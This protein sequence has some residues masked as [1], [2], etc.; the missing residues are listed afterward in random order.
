M[1]KLLAL[2]LLI[3]TPAWAEP[4]PYRL[5][6]DDLAVVINRNDPYSQEIGAYYAKAHEIPPENVIEIDLPVKAEIS[7][8]EL[9]KARTQLNNRLGHNIEALAL[10]WT[11]P[12][13]VSCQSITSA[14]TL[15]LAPNVCQNSCAPT[16]PSPY[17]NSPSVRPWQEVGLRPS[18][19]LAADN[20]AQARAM[21][22]RG[23]SAWG[24]QPRANAWFV[25]TTDKVRSVRAALFP[26]DQYVGALKLTVH[27]LQA[28]SIRN[29]KDVMLYETGRVSVDDLDTVGFLPG[30]L[31][32][33]LTSFGGVITGQNS[34]MSILRWID[35]GATA[36]YGTVSEPCSHPQKFPH[37]QVLLAHYAAGATAVEA[38]WKSVAWPAQGLFVG[39]PLAAPYRRLSAF[40]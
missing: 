22:D 9:E 34:Q 2:L 24:T 12:W 7:A 28:E 33:H 25:Q 1:R 17:F 14:F 32:D 11:Q 21:I 26:R 5:G 3:S 18:M 23:V 27:R 37:P 13:R 38:Y 8:A 29:Q 16:P 31:A 10:A 35:A 4:P 6:A 15:G 19:L 36:S 39:D 30:A 20:I 40:K